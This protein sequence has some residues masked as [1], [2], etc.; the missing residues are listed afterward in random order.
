MLGSQTV[1][2][3]SLD[4]PYAALKYVGKRSLAEE[5]IVVKNS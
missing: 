1:C 5:D 4:A 2:V 3:L